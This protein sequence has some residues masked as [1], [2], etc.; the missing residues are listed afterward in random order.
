MKV[1]RRAPLYLLAFQL[2]F[3]ALG[4]GMVLVINAF[5]NDDPDY[6]YMGTMYAAIFGV[7]F[8]ALL[9]GGS[10]HVTRFTMAVT[11][12][13]IRRAFLALDWILDAVNILLGLLITRGL[14][15]VEQI[16]YRDII[17]P[18]YEEDFP[19]TVLFHWKVVVAL[20]AAGC[21][22]DI[23]LSALLQKTGRKG[24]L[25]IFAVVWGASMLFTKALDLAESGSTSLL[26]RGVGALAGLAGALPLMVWAGV[27]IAVTVA[28]LAVSV[29]YLL[30]KEVRF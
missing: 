15:V 2:G 3:F 9:R 12:G 5:L 7:M 10:N 27:G 8:G 22:L 17:Y 11:M 1:S 4:V 20:V 30:G 26:A 21:V 28:L 14:Y 23:L 19:L 29:V 13:Q 24:Y 18:G 6:F 16:L 25:I